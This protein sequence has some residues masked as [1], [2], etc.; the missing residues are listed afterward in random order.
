MAIF[1]SYV[2]LPEGKH[3]P[4]AKVMPEL[5]LLSAPPFVRSSSLWRVSFHQKLNQ[6]KLSN[7]KKGVLPNHQGN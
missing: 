3:S 7:T 6:V 5:W 4:K 1:N 2:K